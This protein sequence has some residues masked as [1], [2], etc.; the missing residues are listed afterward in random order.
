MESKQTAAE[1]KTPGRDLGIYG[2][3]LGGYE[4]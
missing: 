3:S 2:V 4:V 1:R